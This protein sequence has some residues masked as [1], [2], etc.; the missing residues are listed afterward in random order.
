MSSRVLVALVSVS[1]A[2]AQQITAELTRKTSEVFAA[3]D[4]PGS[5]G[6]AVSVIRNG[7][8]VFQK[9]YGSANL[10]YGIPITPSTVFH[11]ASVSKQ[12]TAAAILLLE[13]DGKLSIDDEIQKYVPELTSFG[14]PVTLRHLLYHTSGIR[15][16]WHLLNISGWRYSRDLITD[17]DVLLVLSRQR[18]LNFEP[19][20]EHM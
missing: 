2:C 5:P 14:A 6:C 17:D 18:D 4:K 10:D 3:Y 20:S 8:P 13:Q 9:G 16:Q 12:F 19:G 7:Q 15:D 1:A 11:V